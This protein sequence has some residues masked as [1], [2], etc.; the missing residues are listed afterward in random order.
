[1]TQT[2]TDERQKTMWRANER[3]GE[4]IRELFGEIHDRGIVPAEQKPLPYLGWSLRTSSLETLKVSYTKGKF[5]LDPKAKWGYPSSQIT[6]ALAYGKA[7]ELLRE[8]LEDGRPPNYAEFQTFLSENTGKFTITDTHKTHDGLEHRTVTV[9]VRDGEYQ[10]PTNYCDACD[11][12]QEFDN[13][14]DLLD[15]F[16][17]AHGEG[18]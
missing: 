13:Y 17:E 10:M 5:W 6:T 1:M 12:T 9:N 4:Y 3:A 15:H 7:I 2:E 18:Q 11:P 14:F 8:S 16:D